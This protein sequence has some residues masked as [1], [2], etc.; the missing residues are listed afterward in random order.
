MSARPADGRPTWV[1]L[2]ALV[3]AHVGCAPAVPV[4]RPPIVDPPAGADAAVA[5]EAEPPVAPPAPA[6]WRT[7]RQPGPPLVR[8]PVERWS[9]VL[10]GPVTEPVVTD[11][12]QLYVVAAD[13]VHALGFDGKVRWTMRVGA[14][15][16]VAVTDEGPVVGTSDGRLLVLDRANGATVRST[17][18]GGPARGVPVQLATSVAW[19]TVHGAVAS[20]ANWGHDVA[21]SAAGGLAADGDAWFLATL[22]GRLVAGTPAG[23]LWEAQ[24]P[25]PAIDGPTLDAAH[26]YVPI[27]A[28]D[29]EAGGVVAFD[30][31]GR[32]VWRHRTDFGPAAALAVGRHL[33]VP[34][35]D[36]KLH[37]LDPQTGEEAWTV[38]GFAEFGMQPA[39]VE[40][41]IY[42]GN[43]DGTLFRID[44]FD[45]GVVWTVKLGAPPTGEPVV[46]RGLLVVGLANGRVV[47]LEEG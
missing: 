38:D 9:V 14:S 5:V 18:A 17:V 36:A 19:V 24:L 1:A 47:A 26:V 12:E 7:G 43:G 6:S 27:A 32:E 40:D 45:G 44:G 35:K 20:T 37:A 39:V 33:L 2:L 13:T 31:E 3:G 11:G 15:G 28:A 4:G 10:P 42:A 30:R 23:R 22:E 41:Q 16:G 46:A 29:G 25:G 8:A 21:L 34:D